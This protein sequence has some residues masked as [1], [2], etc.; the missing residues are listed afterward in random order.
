MSNKCDRVYGP[1]LPPLDVMEYEKL[2]VFFER[3]NVHERT[4]MTFERFCYL[5]EDDQWQKQYAEVFAL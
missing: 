2:G 5:N 1:L 3:Y 4:G